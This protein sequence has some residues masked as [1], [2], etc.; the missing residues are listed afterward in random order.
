MSKRRRALSGYDNFHRSKLR[1]NLAQA[2]AELGRTRASACPVAVRGLAAAARYFGEALGHADSV[3]EGGSG[4]DGGSNP[5]RRDSRDAEVIDR[6]GKA[7]EAATDRI[8]KRCG[9]G[10][11][12]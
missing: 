11:S 9:G 5:M 10:R 6:V 8:A 2:R 1:E 12:R 3:G 7:I 4:G